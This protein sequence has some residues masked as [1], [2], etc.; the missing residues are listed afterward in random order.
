MRLALFSLFMIP[1]VVGC[2]ADE[3]DK[4]D[5]GEEA[6][7][8]ADADAG[9]DADV[10]VEVALLTWTSDDCETASEVL[11]SLSSSVTDEGAVHVQHSNHLTNA[12]VGFEATGSLNTVTDALTVSYTETGEPCDCTSYYLLEYELRGLDAGMYTLSVP[13]GLSDTFVIE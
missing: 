13:D 5:T 7:A 2:D 9:A 11:P 12:C 8:D 6:D 1:L 3:E 10:A 4:P